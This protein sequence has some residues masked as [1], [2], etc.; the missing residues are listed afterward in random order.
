MDEPF[1]SL[2]EIT[3]RRLRADLVQAWMRDRRSVVFVTH[4]IIEACYLADR[5]ILYTPKPTRIAAELEMAL[6]R[7]REYGS[8]DLYLVEKHVLDVFERSL[9]SFMSTNAAVDS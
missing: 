2:D 7:P 8:E 6:P 1:S 4:D 9:K 3:A 5:I